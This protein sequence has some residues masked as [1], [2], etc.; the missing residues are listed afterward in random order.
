MA[1][2]DLKTQFKEF[3]TASPKAPKIVNVPSLPYL[4]ID[5]K[6][7]PESKAFQDAVAALYS[8]AYTIKFDRKKRGEES[9]YPVMALEGL[10]WSDD[11]SNFAKNKRD[12]WK[13]TLMIQQPN[14]ITK[15]DLKT[16]TNEVIEKKHLE[17]AKNVRL[18]KF[19]EGKAAQIMHVGPYAT[20]NR[21]IETLH[22]FVHDQGAELRGKHHEIYFGDP[23]RTAPEKL[24]TILRQPISLN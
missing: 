9:D 15:N 19:K 2:I 14:I 5:G 1:K 6:G 7:A 12:E 13:W 20:E 21:T 8:L 4:M 16:A 18:E 10:W 23:R 11:I 22:A 24:K 3:F 17:A